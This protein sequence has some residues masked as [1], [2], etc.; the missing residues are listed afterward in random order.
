MPPH[1][2]PA[3]PL[4]PHGRWRPAVVL[5][6]LALQACA[7][8]RHEPPAATPAL[9]Q[10]RVLGLSPQ[11]PALRPLLAAQGVATAP[12][13][14]PVWDAKALRALALGRHPEMQLARAEQALAN[15]GRDAERRAA[16]PPLL[17]GTETTLDHH[18]AAGA[19]TSPWSL[20]VVL[21]LAELPLAGPLL[22]LSPR[23][24]REAAADALADEAALKSA[25]T[26]WRVHRGVRDAHRALWLAEQAA[27]LADAQWRLRSEA[28]TAWQTRLNAGAADARAL[29]QVRQD[30]AEAA[31]ALRDAQSAR[32]RARQALAQ[33]IGLTDAQ[34]ETMT[35]GFAELQSSQAVTIDRQALQRS[36]LLDRLDVRAGVARYAAADAALRLALSQQLPSLVL[37]PGWAWDQGDRR[38]SLGVGVQWPAVDGNRAAIA[39]AGARR[40]AEAA[41]FDLLQ[42]QALAELDVARSAVDA[43]RREM[44]QAQTQ[45]ELAAKSADRAR[46]R[47]SG[48]SA[49]RLELL[50]A[51]RTVLDARRRVLD[52]R[53]AQAGAQAELEDAVQRPLD[54]VAPAA[55]AAAPQLARALA[56]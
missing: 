23:Q 15:A 11:D 39:Q 12:W 52:A 44:R 21:D 53:A 47:L 26:A 13:P 34:A 49:D 40:D 29:A 45:S 2:P 14:L 7:L 6:A 42:L 35:F 4:R 5:L 10:A 33:A 37:K 31:R 8:Q 50:D 48:G 3:Q 1:P 32:Q 41:A 28:S 38:W 27:E 36:A 19:S 51:R 22:G 43:A 55:T 24:A 25:Q 9:A 30:E 17:R 46:S 16:R 20:G 54:T 56:P 18:S